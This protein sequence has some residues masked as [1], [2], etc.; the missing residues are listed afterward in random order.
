MCYFFYITRL[1]PI[2]AKERLAAWQYV[3]LST[4]RRNGSVGKEIEKLVFML[5]H[6]QDNSYFIANVRLKV[7]VCSG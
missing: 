4:I 7:Y 6:I 1:A 3:G 2:S 5:P